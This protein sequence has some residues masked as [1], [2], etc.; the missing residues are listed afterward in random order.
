MLACDPHTQLSRADVF[1]TGQLSLQLHEQADRC[2][3]SEH[4]RK[5][6][7]ACRDVNMHSIIDPARGWRLVNVKRSG[8][9]HAFSCEIL[10]SSSGLHSGVT[11]SVAITASD[12]NSSNNRIRPRPEPACGDQ[13]SVSGNPLPF[14][15]ARNNSR[16]T[17]TMKPRQ[18]GH[19]Q[20]A[21]RAMEGPFRVI[22]RETGRAPVSSDG[23]PAQALRHVAT[24]RGLVRTLHQIRPL[25]ARRE[26]GRAGASSQ[27]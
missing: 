12:S 22:L 21:M 4:P 13:R 27:L 2:M 1:L 26:H 20:I 6:E 16:M 11:E 14:G 23:N 18:S 25:V 5:A 24:P 9:R 15:R 7:V 17:A 8:E 3:T 10:P 19:R